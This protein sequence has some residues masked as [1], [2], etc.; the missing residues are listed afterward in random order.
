VTVTCVWHMSVSGIL[1]C[2]AYETQCHMLDICQTYV[3][4]KDY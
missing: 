4:L 2:L 1:V 3:S